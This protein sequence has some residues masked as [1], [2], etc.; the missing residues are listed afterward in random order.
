MSAGTAR[1]GSIGALRGSPVSDRNGSPVQPAARWTSVAVYPPAGSLASKRTSVGAGVCAAATPG[2]TNNAPMTA[3]AIALLMLQPNTLASR[4]ASRPPRSEARTAR[5]ATGSGRAGSLRPTLECPLADELLD[6]ARQRRL[7]V[8]RFA[9]VGR[10]DDANHAVVERTHLGLPF[11]PLLR[12]HL[13][14]AVHLQVLVRDPV[15][16]VQFGL[17]AD[18]QD[19]GRCTS[20]SMV[21]ATAGFCI[22]APSFGAFFDVH[23]TISAPL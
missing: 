23:M 15:N 20:V 9:H 10:D 21:R 4:H 13:I 7:E 2:A 17:P 19:R 3:A 1:T 18:V 14:A 12:G 6:R 8:D 11:D 5:E 22:A 16:D